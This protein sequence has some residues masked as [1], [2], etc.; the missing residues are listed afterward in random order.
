MFDSYFTRILT[1]VPVP[2]GHILEQLCLSNHPC[3]CVSLSLS[4]RLS[5]SPSTCTVIQESLN[6]YS[7]NWILANFTKKKLPVSLNF[8]FYC[9]IL[10]TTLREEADL[11]TFQYEWD[12][13]SLTCTCAFLSLPC[14]CTVRI[15]LWKNR[16]VRKTKLHLAYFKCLG[17]KTEMPCFSGSATTQ[18]STMHYCST[19][20]RTL[21]ESNAP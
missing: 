7:W 17:T 19:V 3:L 15:T 18:I 2:M 13:V 5:V 9:T 10:T 12:F 1:H 6:I 14:I 11:R 20:A 16:Q 4:V 21:R 8:H